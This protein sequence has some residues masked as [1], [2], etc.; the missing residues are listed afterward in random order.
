MA[1]KAGADPVDFRLKNLTDKRLIRVL[2]TA[3]EKFGWTPKKGG[4]AAASALPAAPTP[5]VAWLGW[6][7]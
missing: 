2:K 7:R 3:A 6:P 5:A 4:T 1:A